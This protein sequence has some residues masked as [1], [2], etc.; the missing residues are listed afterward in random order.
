VAGRARQAPHVSLA[1]F[2]AAM[3]GVR[4][5]ALDTSTILIAG[6]AQDP[7]HACAAWLMD[8]VERGA[9]GECIISA[10][11]VTE[12]LVRPMSASFSEGV[13]AQTALRN[14]PH[15]DVATLDFDTAVEVA[16][17]RAVT[18]LKTPDAVVIGTAI[19]H[20]VQAIVH[21]DGDWARKAKTYSKTLTFICLD[22]HC[23]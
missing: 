21:A 10:I 7:R 14:Y 22:D 20:Q 23:P 5:L 2:Q 17:V 12:T 3:T 9:F 13:A 11:T 16:H 18:K 19:A 1:T 6:D 8:E 15:L 4:R